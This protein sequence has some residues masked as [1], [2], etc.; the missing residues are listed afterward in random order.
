[1]QGELDFLL[2]CLFF[3]SVATFWVLYSTPTKNRIRNWF[4]GGFAAISTALC[5]FFLLEQKGFTQFLEPDL[6]F[7]LFTVYCLFVAASCVA[8]IVDLYFNTN[9]LRGEV[10]YNQY[11]GDIGIA[12]LTVFTAPLALFFVLLPWFLADPS[13]FE[14]KSTMRYAFGVAE[15]AQAGLDGLMLF[16]LDQTGKAIF[17]DIA[18]VYRF[19]LTNLSNNPE[20]LTFS[21][22]CLIYRTLVAVYV[23]VIAY[24]LIFQ[25]AAK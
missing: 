19:G 23:T 1:M 24:R 21:T 12:A 18:E 22:A 8:Y 16:A 20:H 5:G 4:I 2:Q 11:G 3:G 14:V 17:F 9:E 25:P 15:P 7:A 6:E 10:A 13:I